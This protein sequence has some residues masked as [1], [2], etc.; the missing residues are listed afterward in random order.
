MKQTLPAAG[1]DD[2]TYC[3]VK[4]YM[5]DTNLNQ[6]P[7]LVLD[8]RD[9]SR[10]RESVPSAVVPLHALGIKQVENYLTLAVHLEDEGMHDAAGAIRQLV[11]DRSYQL[12]RLRWLEEPR[13]IPLA[14]AVP[15][16]NPIFPHWPATTW[17][18]K[19]RHGAVRPR[20]GH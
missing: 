19:V 6:D 7:L 9:A 13:R 17:E 1:N 4:P 20:K 8:Q 18:L 11:H 12:K 16:S 3:I 10:V 2:D 14:I 15:A 5:R